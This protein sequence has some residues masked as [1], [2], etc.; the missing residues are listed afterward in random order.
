MN[1]IIIMLLADMDMKPFVIQQQPLSRFG[2]GV[3]DI[4]GKFDTLA[5]AKA[6]F[7]QLPAYGK[8]SYRIAQARPHISYDPL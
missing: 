1:D 4:C 2:S 3:W 8:V 5:E 7:G 6:V